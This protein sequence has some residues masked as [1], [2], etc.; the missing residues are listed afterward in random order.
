MSI[1]GYIYV[2]AYVFIRVC[3]STY[4]HTLMFVCGMNVHLWVCMCG[5]C[6]HTFISVHIHSHI[7]EC[8]WCECTSVGMYVWDVCMGCMFIHV[9]PYTYIHTLTSVCGLNV[10]L[11]VCMCSVCVH[12]CISIHIHSHIDS[13]CGMN[14][15]LWV[16]MCGVCIHT[17]TSVHIHSHIGECMWCE[18]SSV[19]MYVFGMC[20]YVYIH[21]HTFTH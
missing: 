17:F 9:Y 18:C 5:V 15:H 7:D 2:W 11:W 8:M 6:I 12:M 10:D 13:L 4:I 19:G 14:V 21:T 16:C 20:S 1:C 3:P